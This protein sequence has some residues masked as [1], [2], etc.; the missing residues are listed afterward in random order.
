[1]DVETADLALVQDGRPPEL[2]EPGRHHPGELG[3]LARDQVL[4]LAVVAPGDPWRVALDLDPLDNEIRVV[5]LPA[6]VD[7]LE[8]AVEHLAEAVDTLVAE[9]PLVDE[10]ISVDTLAVR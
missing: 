4:H 9:A 10:D 8:R 1:M 2:V 6:A 3:K 7:R 5:G